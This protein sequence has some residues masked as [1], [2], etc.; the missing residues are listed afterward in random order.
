MQLERGDKRPKG[1]RIQ[2]W[3]RLQPPL[4]YIQSV[5][6]WWSA[7]LRSMA[8]HAPVQ[9]SDFQEGL[10]DS[11]LH[12][13]SLSPERFSLEGARQLLHLS[14]A[15]RQPSP[16]SPR[17]VRV[18]SGRG[19][20][21]QPH[22][23]VQRCHSGCR[24]VGF[25]PL[26]DDLKTTPS[27]QCTSHGSG[28]EWGYGLGLWSAPAS[29]PCWLHERPWSSHRHEVP[30]PISLLGSKIQFW[31]SATSHESTSHAY[32]PWPSQNWLAGLQ[33]RASIETMRRNQRTPKLQQ[34]KQPHTGRCGVLLAATSALHILSGLMKAICTDWFTHSS[35]I[36]QGFKRWIKMK[37]REKNEHLIT[38]AADVLTF[39]S[40][41][42]SELPGWEWLRVAIW[43]RMLGNLVFCLSVVG[44]RFQLETVWR[45]P[46]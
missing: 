1:F 37:M 34:N 18:L 10:Q 22:H 26:P 12:F 20:A 8:M 3:Q 38:K 11:I 30:L 14:D 35:A 29:P 41:R 15:W 27:P 31:K 9:G 44:C 23:A 25:V 4:G 17:S 24:W 33:S 43:S 32:S 13:S 39:A 40:Q 21:D 36:R 6:G 7:T 19:P 5:S 28:M 45:L 42:M 16:S 46:L 2:P